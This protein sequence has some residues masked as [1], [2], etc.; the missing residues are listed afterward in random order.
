MAALNRAEVRLIFDNDKSY[1]SREPELKIPL[2]WSHEMY[3][4]SAV[5]DDVDL[6][7]KSSSCFEELN[8]VTLLTDEGGEAAHIEQAMA[9]SGGDGIHPE[10]ETT[11]HQGGD[12][13]LHGI[14]DRGADEIIVHDDPRCCLCVQ[15]VEMRW[16]RQCLR[17]MNITNLTCGGGC[18]RCW[19]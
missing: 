9:G 12:R 8:L 10:R 2:I 18:R 7:A 17:Y 13:E 3:V 4:F 5:V 16:R 15:R 11:A 14:R 1:L 6:I 19:R